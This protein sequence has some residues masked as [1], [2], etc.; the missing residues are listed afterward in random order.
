[1]ADAFPLQ[2]GESASWIDGDGAEAS[3]HCPPNGLLMLVRL[4]GVCAVRPVFVPPE[5]IQI[6]SLPLFFSFSVLHPPCDHAG[7]RE[8]GCG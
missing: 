4:D 7:G 5:L 1:M 2:N 3:G 8:G 6:G